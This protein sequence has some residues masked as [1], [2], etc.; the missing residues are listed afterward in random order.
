MGLEVHAILPQGLNIP[1]LVI[2]SEYLCK[3]DQFACNNDKCVSFIHECDGENNCG[4]NSDED[5]CS[6]FQY[7]VRN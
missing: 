5:I 1:Y 6:K 4:D 7:S 3:S 2:P